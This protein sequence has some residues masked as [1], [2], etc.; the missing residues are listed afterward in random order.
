MTMNDVWI[1]IKFKN[2]YSDS[3]KHGLNLFFDSSLAEETICIIKKYIAFLLKQYFFPTRCNLFFSKEPTIN[4][5]G[6]NRDVFLGGASKK[7]PSIYIV[8]RKKGRNMIPV[9]RKLTKLLT[10]YFQWYFYFDKSRETK[11]NNREANLFA[12]YLVGE[13]LLFEYD[14]DD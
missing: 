11:I 3:K 9:L 14:Y 5:N 6:K 4:N 8:I 10:N 12:R 2:Y 1:N 13:F 7:Y